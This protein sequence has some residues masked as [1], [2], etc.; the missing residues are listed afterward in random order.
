[1]AILQLE[2]LEGWKF[3]MSCVYAMDESLQ[4]LVLSA[5]LVVEVQVG[6]VG[7]NWMT[8]HDSHDQET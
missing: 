4:S 8:N 6:S 1:M 2:I 5:R 7:L 3:E